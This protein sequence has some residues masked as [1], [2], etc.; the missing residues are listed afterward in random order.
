MCYIGFVRYILGGGS[1]DRGGR[2]RDRGGRD[3]DRRDD[4]DRG[5]RNASSAAN[6]GRPFHPDDRCYECGDRGHYARDCSRF[7][8]GGGSGGGGRSGG[9]SARRR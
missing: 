2:D 8:S 7:G 9:R 5:S 3:R 1:R 4:R 6:N